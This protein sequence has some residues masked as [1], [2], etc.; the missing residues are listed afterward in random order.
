VGERTLM[1]KLIPFMDAGNWLFY[2]PHVILRIMLSNDDL[3]AIRTPST[4]NNLDLIDPKGAYP[5]EGIRY[6]VSVERSPEKIIIDGR[7][8]VTIGPIESRVGPFRYVILY[9]EF[10]GHPIGYYDYGRTVFLD[11]GDTF[12]I[13]FPDNLVTVRCDENTFGRFY[14]E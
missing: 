1:A 8:P 13:Q 10:S 12:T 14:F 7:G 5:K 11:P 2:D 6:N 4:I 9:N 3:I